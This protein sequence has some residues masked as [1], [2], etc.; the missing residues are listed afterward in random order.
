MS[1]FR[2]ANPDSVLK[3]LPAERQEAIADHARTHTLMQTAEWL[4]G[5][6]LKTNPGS[7]SRWLSWFSLRAQLTQNQSAVEG[8][9]DKLKVSNPTWT[10]EQLE[11]AGQ[12]FFAEMALTQQDSK[13]WHLMQ[14]LNLKRKQLEHDKARA[15]EELRLKQEALALELQKF[16]RTTCEL[17][18]KWQ[19]DQRARDIAASPE[20]NDAKIEQLGVLMFG[21]EWKT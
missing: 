15:T 18:V 20:S 7:L 10:P 9:L 17:F 12:V 6:G 1:T 13:A 2:K 16:Q 11:A 8:L 4:R 5:D 3:T 14:T 21:E 19:S